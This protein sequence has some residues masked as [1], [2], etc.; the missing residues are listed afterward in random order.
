MEP[1]TYV[2][3]AE[4]AA[5]LVRRMVDDGAVF[6]ASSAGEGTVR[7][8]AQWEDGKEPAGS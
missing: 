5:E 7:F 4:G 2:V 6:R 8:V 3:D 1:K